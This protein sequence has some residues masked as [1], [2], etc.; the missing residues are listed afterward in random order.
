MHFT[1]VQSPFRKMMGVR[2]IVKCDRVTL[3][4]CYGR[5]EFTAPHPRAVRGVHVFEF[6]PIA[7]KARTFQIAS[8]H[9]WTH[10]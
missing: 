8:C 9:N 6:H 7:T 2:S 4:P 10:A 5:D 3:K 1:M